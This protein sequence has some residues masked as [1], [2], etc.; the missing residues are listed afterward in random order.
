MSD[1]ILAVLGR[2]ET[3]SHVLKAAEQLC[4]LAGQATL[5]ALAIDAPQHLDPLV[6]EALI[7][8]AQ[9][10][11][12]L[13]EREQTRLAALA[14]AFDAWAAAPPPGISAQ[15]RKVF[16]TADDIVEEAGRRADFIVIAQ[17]T[18]QDDPQTRAGFRAALLRSWRPVLVVPSGAPASFG[19]IVAVAW[20]EDGRASKALIPALRLL[21]G[22]AEFHVLQGIRG[23]PQA[24]PVP[25]AVSDHGIAARMHVLAIQGV[26][27]QVLL[28][29]AHA[30]GADLLVMGAYAHTPLRE[31]IFGGVTRFML[32]HADLPVLMRH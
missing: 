26:F 11:D 9:I 32:D 15:W 14:S 30:L 6:A 3:A 27:G 21:S 22:A 17:P 29:K 20:R 31:M 13:R 1:V 24:L 5:I 12:E 25:A 7:A 18:A 16:G 2:P 10:A 8:E 4:A 28:D 19:R 23:G